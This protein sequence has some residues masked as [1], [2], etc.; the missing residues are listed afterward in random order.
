MDLIEKYKKLKIN[1][2]NLCNNIIHVTNYKIYRALES[3]DFI[4]DNFVIPSYIVKLLNKQYKH[5]V[6]VSDFVDLN[7][8]NYHKVK[9]YINIFLNKEKQLR[10]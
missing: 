8:Y 3:D 6:F 10:K 7:Y 5:N 9:K 1:E 2:I 4:V